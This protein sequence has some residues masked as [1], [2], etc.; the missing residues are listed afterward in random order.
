MIVMKMRENISLYLRLCL[1]VHLRGNP[2]P[3][4]TSSRSIIQHTNRKPDSNMP[5]LAQENPTS[6]K[7]AT[8]VVSP[9]I[10]HFNAVAM[11]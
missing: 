6:L 5:P 9:S 3:K 7:P 10:I 2:N 4:A 11:R 1:S 8:C